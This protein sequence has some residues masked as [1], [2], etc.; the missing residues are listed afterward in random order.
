MNRHLSTQHGANGPDSIACDLTALDA[1]ERSRHEALSRRLRSSVLEVKETDA[2][3]EFIGPFRTDEFVSA[4]E[5]VTLERRCCPWIDFE[6]R[7][8]GR[9]DRFSV[10]LKAEGRAKEFM[11]SLYGIGG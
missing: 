11:K 9:A 6:L 3:F 4:A 1:A 8:G 2:G 10:V 7:L 5:W